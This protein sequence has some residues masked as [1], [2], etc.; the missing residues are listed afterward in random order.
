MIPVFDNDG[1]LPPGEHV[2]GWADIEQRFGGNPRRDWLLGGLRRALEA[3]K[4]AG[5]HSAYI[6]GSFV[7][8]KVEPKD[9]DGAWDIQ[10]VK[11]AL[12]DPVFLIFDH[13][14]LLQK[15]KYHG[16]FFPAQWPEAASGTVFLEFFQTRTDNGAEKG[17]IRIDLDTLT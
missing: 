13:D 6:D 5:C 2:A 1:Y 3:L 15:T 14:R 12:L 4:R 7:T 9:Y 11:G 10:D 17:I 8:D 16:E